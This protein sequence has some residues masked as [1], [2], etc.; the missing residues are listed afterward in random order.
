MVC[1]KCGKQLPDGANFC[2]GCGAQLSAQSQPEAQPQSQSGGAA[3]K[4][5]KLLWGILI[6]VAAALVG[7]LA[8]Y[9]IAGTVDSALDSGKTSTSQVSSGQ[10]SSRLEDVSDDGVTSESYKVIFTDQDIAV[11]TTDFFATDLKTVSYAADLGNGV[12]QNIEYAYE[13]GIVVAMSDTVYMSVSG[14]SDGDKAALHSQ[15]ISQMSAY[16]AMD[17]CTVST[18]QGFTHYVYKVTMTDL[19]D[20]DNIRRAAMYG[21]LNISDE[22]VEVIGVK[23]SEDALLSQGY[24]KR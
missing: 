6:V 19:D 14:L 5:G 15:L 9:L 8:G 20:A 4:G 18:N 13:N 10:S 1:N 24:T 16:E 2:S 12:V 3:K 17:F 23:A 11:P 22:N 21:L 7:R